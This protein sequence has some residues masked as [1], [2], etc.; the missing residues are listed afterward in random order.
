MIGT[1]FCLSFIFCRQQFTFSS[2]TLFCSSYTHL[3]LDLT[4][5]DLDSGIMFYIIFW[6]I[7]I[8]RTSH[9]TVIPSISAAKSAVLHNTVLGYSSFCRRISQLLIH[10]S[11]SKF[12]SPTLPVLVMDHSS[13]QYS[14]TGFNVKIQVF[15]DVT[16]FRWASTYWRSEGS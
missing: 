11:S 12:P 10:T 13:H 6:S 15:C 9:F 5:S 14:A 2:R 7:Q 4:T 1:Y 16:F 3:G 8:S